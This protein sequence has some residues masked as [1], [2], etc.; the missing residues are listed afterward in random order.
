MQTGLSHHQSGRLQEAESVYESVLKEQ[1][2]HPDALHLLGVVAHHLGKN[3]LAVDLI[4]RAIKVNP[5]EPNYHYNCGGAYQALGKN[6]EA[7]AQF[8]HALSLK[9]DY[10]EAHYNLGNIFQ[11]Q[12]RLEEAIVCYEESLTLKPDYIKSLIN[13]G[14]VLQKSGRLDDAIARFEQVLALKPDYANAYN[15]LGTALKEQ[16]KMNEAIARYK[17]AL[18]IRPDYVGAHNNLGIIFQEQGQLDEA[19][20]CYKKAL[21]IKP[22]FVEA[23]CNLGIALKQ[24]GRLDEAIHGYEQALAIKPNYTKAI[25][26]L[27]SIR[28][29]QEYIL[30]IKKLLLESS[31][32]D[33]DAI[34]CH[35]A[36]GIIY[37]D[38]GMFS[39]AFKNY[40]M[41]NTL[42]RRNLNYNSKS[43][44]AYVDRL[45]QVYSKNYFQENPVCV[46]NSKSHVFIVGM[47]RSGTTLV[48]QIVSRHPQ[49][50][51]A[52]E[53]SSFQ[54]IENAIAKE[55]E[56]SLPYPDCISLCD[57][58]VLEKY[59]AIYLKEMEGYLKEAT[60]I[61]DK[62]PDNF[63]KIG[64]I[65]ILF[66]RAKIIHCRRN[67]LDTC[68]SI[69]LNYFDVGNEYSFNLKELG[70]YYLDYKKI[71]EHWRKLF[72]SEIF[73][74]QYEDLVNKQEKVSKEL[75]EYLELEW[76]EKCMDFYNNERAVKTASNV[77]VRQ[78][79]YKTSIDRWK[80]YEK[81]LD[82]LVTVLKSRT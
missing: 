80:Q 4:E 53:L 72:S 22:E 18:V 14:V 49:V 29:K 61:T 79:M 51:G 56:K 25:H 20:A 48:E 69:Y 68:T 31:L 38:I 32:S 34:H 5:D 57:K 67:V 43:H 10:I 27:A 55:F 28:P 1:P 75:V 12:G 59:S 37:N 50:Y 26:G 30:V 45:I 17:Q 66:P 47:P 9:P 58:F 24:H 39:K 70:Q 81:Y 42:K 63:L 40:D 60:R 35:F 6:V 73:D 23:Y 3:D 71:M 8:E 77:Q 76:D 74:V 62:M 52:G 2:E 44:S 36:L 11:T 82:P 64:L 15:N 54:R 41:G 19:V 33:W 46:S 65:K 16:G 21:A 78:P 7:V 13:L